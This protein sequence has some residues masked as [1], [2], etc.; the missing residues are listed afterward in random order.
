MRQDMFANF[1]AKGMDNV[2]THQLGF[3]PPTLIGV[4]I[5][6]TITAV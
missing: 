5:D 2:P 1:I 6:V 3:V 4:V